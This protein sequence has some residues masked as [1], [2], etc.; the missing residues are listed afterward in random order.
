MSENGYSH[1]AK[2]QLVQEIASLI[3]DMSV[4]DACEKVGLGKST[5][6]RWLAADKDVWEHYTHARE[7]LA[8]KNEADLEDIN[9]QV[10]N[11]QLEPAAA[12]VISDNLKWM[13]GRR[14][15]KAFGD[16]QQVEHTGTGFTI[17]IQEPKA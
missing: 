9:R 13:M 15:Q 4:V 11:A 14:N 12:R 10:A 3:V 2:M 7:A 6:F 1:E 16:R 8:F 5:F 17:N